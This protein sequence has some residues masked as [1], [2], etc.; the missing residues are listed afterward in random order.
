[1]NRL[2]RV[3]ALIIAA[4]SIGRLYPI[5]GRFNDFIYISDEHCGDRIKIETVLRNFICK[6]EKV[7]YTQIILESITYVEVV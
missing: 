4:N 2:A 5:A 7:D 6:K 1:M 3:K